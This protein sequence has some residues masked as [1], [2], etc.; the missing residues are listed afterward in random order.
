MLVSRISGQE[1]PFDLQR[2]YLAV[3]GVDHL[4][5]VLCFLV[6][7]FEQ[8]LGVLHPILYPGA[9]HAR[10]DTVLR[11]TFGQ[12]LLP[13]PCRPRN[14]RFEWRTVWFTLRTHDLRSFEPI[15][16]ILSNCPTTYYV[17]HTSQR[18]YHG[19]PRKNTEYKTDV[20]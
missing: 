10:R 6:T 11:R 15:S 9:D 14:L 20:G 4:L 3:Q 13:W 7:A 12:S 8:V 19:I 17:R 5:R 1:I 2:A 18:R 16:F